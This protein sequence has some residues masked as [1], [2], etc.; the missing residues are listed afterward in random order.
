V[1]T[2]SRF[3]LF[4]TRSFSELA[5]PCLNCLATVIQRG[6]TLIAPVTSPWWH[7]TRAPRCCGAPEDP[8]LQTPAVVL[9]LSHTLPTL[10]HDMP[11]QHHLPTT[12]TA[13]ARRL[14]QRGPQR[15]QPPS[16]QSS[17][18]ST[19]Q[20]HAHTHVHRP[21][22]TSTS[23]SPSPAR[24]GV[25]FPYHNISKL[26]VL[27]G[28]VARTFTKNKPAHADHMRPGVYF[29]HR[30]HHH[31]HHRHSSTKNNLHHQYCYTP[32]PQRQFSPIPHRRRKEQ[33]PTASAQGSVAKL[34]G[35]ART[36]SP[37][38]KAEQ[39]HSTQDSHVVP[40]HGTN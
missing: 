22:S 31:H 23:T 27:W 13:T 18:T 24:N 19:V 37:S 36:P 28:W 38:V 20:H 26:Q 34:S 16:E 9:Q 29:I 8:P 4:S 33:N 10:L 2:I 17:N 15:R 39:N 14:P 30:H 1:T 12:T 5:N 3:A 11:R 21:S 35:A 25:P 6:P 32:Q 7:A 40:H